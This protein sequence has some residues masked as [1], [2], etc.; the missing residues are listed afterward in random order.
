MIEAI[1]V[2]VEDF[3]DDELTDE[4]LDRHPSG[5]PRYC[6]CGNSVCDTRCILR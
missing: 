4:S 6:T 3:L 2:E 1:E 5:D